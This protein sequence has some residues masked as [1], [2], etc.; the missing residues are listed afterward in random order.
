MQSLLEDT[1]FVQIIKVFL[2]NERKRWRR[3]TEG[4]E[5]A[6]WIKS[7]SS[8]CLGEKRAWQ[9]ILGC[10]SWFKFRPEEKLSFAY[11][12]KRDLWS[13]ASWL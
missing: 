8:I 9:S 6:Y 11:C 10:F 3:I 1:L 7:S 12:V 4:K 13:S 2:N 5:W